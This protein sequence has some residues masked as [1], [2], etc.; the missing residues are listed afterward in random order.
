MTRAEVI[1]KAVEGKIQWVQAATILRVS[2]RHL[3][4]L[5]DLHE[6]GGM[7]ALLDKRAG[8]PRRK[9]VKAKTVEEVLRLRRE[10]YA[11]FSVKHFHER[12]LEKHGFG[13]SYTWTKQLLQAAGLAEKAPARGKYRRKRE[14]RPMRGMMVHLDGSTHEWIRGEPMRD[15]IVMLDDADGKPLWGKFV[16]QEGTM[17]TMEAI[18][19]VVRKYGRF[20]DLYTD[21]GSHFC[22]T[23][24]A[25]QAPDERQDGQVSRGTDRQRRRPALGWRS[26]RAWREARRRCLNCRKRFST[27]P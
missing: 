3:R 25:G 2:P 16:E 19:A 4:R 22:R 21:R 17:S 12:L 18:G 27:A 10:R 6:K 8:T 20:G 9:R 14:R 13:I 15:L 11:E 26:I 24:R 5:R 1:V 23:T 7:E